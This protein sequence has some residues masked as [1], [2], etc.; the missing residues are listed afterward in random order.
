MALQVVIDRAMHLDKEQR[1]AD[2]KVMV[3]DMFFQVSSDKQGEKNTQV[4]EGNSLLGDQVTRYLFA[5]SGRVAQGGALSN[6]IEDV[7]KKCKF[8]EKSQKA[9]LSG[10]RVIIQKNLSMDNAERIKGIFDQS[11]LIG[12]IEEMPTAT[13]I[14]SRP[15]SFVAEVSMPTPVTME[16]MTIGDLQELSQLKVVED[17]PASIPSTYSNA[18]ASGFSGG[19]AA[20]TGADGFYPSQLKK[21]NA[22]RRRVIWS[23]ISLLS[24]ALLAVAWFYKPVH[25]KLHDIWVHTVLGKSNVRGV[26][27][28][29]INVGMSAAFSGSARELGRSMRMGVEAYFAF[30]NEAGGI[31][32]RK[33][34]LTAK[35]DNYEP[36]LAQENVKGFLDPELGVLAML[37]NVGTPTAKAILPAVLENN[38]LLFGTFSGASLLRNS[39]P[40]RY[41][42]NYR[43]SYTE[44]TEA[45]VHYFV[46]VKNI[47]P[48]KIAVFYQNDSFGQDGLAGVEK[49][50]GE[51][52]IKPTEILTSVYQRNTAQ[53]EQAVAEFLPEQKALEGIVVVGTY[54]ASAAFTREMRNAGYKGD[55]ANVSFVGAR[56]LVELLL[57]LGPSYAENILITQVVPPYD[58]YAT[59][60]LNYRKSLNKYFPNEEPN[61]IS[62][63]GFISATIFTEGLSRSGRY[64]TEDE[65]VNNLESIQELDLGIG[66]II[67]FGTSNHQASHRVWGVTINPD[68]S[69]MNVSLE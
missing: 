12:S 23:V 41:V 31:H 28:N 69:F 21:K 35:N 63:E 13:R 4:A 65:L 9:L 55:I 14:A 17:G 26:S 5:F 34:Y 42:F 19:G 15:P 22:T 45:I 48:K 66:S 2:V 56:A 46:N 47:D 8:S 58:S 1:Y 40:D 51:Y 50:L 60:V 52:H 36:Q 18:S 53:V 11:G 67:S 27:E 30:V 6:A 38:T 64:F 24:L 29:R 16:P 7:S 3:S 10:K 54:S 61:F 20:R 68:G 32:G 37:G 49:A 25:Y 62:L 57:E 39:P 43:A 59:G 44:E 33:L